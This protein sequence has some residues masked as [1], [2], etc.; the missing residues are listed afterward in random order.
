MEWRLGCLYGP[1][2]INFYLLLP[3]SGEEFWIGSFFGLGCSQH[4]LY[5]IIA[6]I[7]AVDIWEVIYVVTKYARKSRN[8]LSCSILTQV[9]HGTTISPKML[10]LTEILDVQN[11]MI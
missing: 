8:S 11:L 9:Q 3:K 1:P 2:S 10:S 7:K 5:Y 6:L 4:R